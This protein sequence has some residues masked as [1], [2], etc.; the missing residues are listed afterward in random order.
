METFMVNGRNYKA[1]DIDFN[2]V[3]LLGENDIELTDIAKK[4]LPALRLYIAF[5]LN[6]TPEIA[7]NEINLHIVNGGSFQ[8]LLAVFNEKLEDSD[9]F[10]AIGKKMPEEETT[11]TPKK[12]S[13]KSQ[14]DEE[15]SE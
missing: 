10:R 9:F 4:A 5:C 13:K 7:G 6:A 8:E 15:V 14:K 1:K 2:F 11:E 12:N 3:C